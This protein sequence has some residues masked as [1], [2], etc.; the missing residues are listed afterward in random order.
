[1]KRPDFIMLLGGAAVRPLA[2]HA[3]QKAMPVIGFLIPGSQSRLG[4]F[5]AAFRQGLSETG[6]VEGQNPVI[7]Y[8]WAEINRERCRRWPPN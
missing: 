5:T 2:A 1:M 4:S 6:Y 7:E 8:G 3:R